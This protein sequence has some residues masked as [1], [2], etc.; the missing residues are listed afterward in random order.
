MTNDEIPGLAD[1]LGGQVNR[2]IEDFTAAIRKAARDGYIGDLYRTDYVVSGR[3]A[4][5]ID[6]LRYTSSWPMDESDARAIEDSIEHADSTD[7]FTIRL[8]RNHRD[9]QPQLANDRWESKFRW[10]V[11]RVINTVRL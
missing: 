6:M 7:P 5:P 11:M 9:P 2:A 10:R 8:S 1:D 4:F 3:G